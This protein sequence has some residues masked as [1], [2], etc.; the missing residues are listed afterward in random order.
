MVQPSRRR[1]DHLM[2]TPNPVPPPPEDPARDLLSYIPVFEVVVGTGALLAAAGLTLAVV[3]ALRRRRELG[4]TWTLIVSAYVLAILGAGLRIMLE[5]S[6]TSYSG[7]PGFVVHLLSE[8]FAQLAIG[9]VLLGMVAVIL[10]VVPALRRRR[11]LIITWVLCVSVL[12][13]ATLVNLGLF[14]A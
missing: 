14:A 1:D 13:L 12:L 5:P 8:P 10:A 2:A 6:L 7:Q 11:A 9:S 3:P 4:I